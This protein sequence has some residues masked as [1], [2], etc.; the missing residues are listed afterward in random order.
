MTG[1]SIP[2]SSISYDNVSGL[3]TIVAST[4]HGFGFGRKIKISGSNEEIY[5]GEFVVTEVLDDLGI[6]TYSFVVEIGSSDSAPTATGNIKA[7]H[8]GF[9]S[10]AG[11]IEV[12]DENFSGRMVETYDNVTSTLFA[13]VP[14][15]ITTSIRI[16]GLNELGLNIGDYLM[17]GDEIVRISHTVS[18][19]PT[20]NT[21]EVFR[22]VLGTKRSTHLANAVVRRLRIKSVEFR[23]HSIIRASGHTFE[24]VGFGPGNYSTARPERHDRAI[25]ADEELLAQSTKRSGWYQLL[26][27]NE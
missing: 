26:Y 4:S 25:T 10:N 19:D 5:N 3:A 9:S 11:D 7:H 23:R 18:Y 17:I 6:P 1:K 27:C 12:D 8:L 20:N 21:V 14:N 22:G 13:N 16:S 2:V 15:T 24:Y